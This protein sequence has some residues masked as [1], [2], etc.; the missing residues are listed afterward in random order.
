[1]RFI[2]SSKTPR[3][4]DASIRCHARPGTDQLLSEHVCVLRPGRLIVIVRKISKGGGISGF[5][6]D[7]GPSITERVGLSTTYRLDK[8]K[9]WIGKHGNGLKPVENETIPPF[10]L[11]KL[12]RLKRSL[13]EK[14][15]LALIYRVRGRLSGPC[16]LSRREDRHGQCNQH[17]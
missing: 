8:I 3:C 16:V 13:D 11:F 2:F 15:L 9:A 12:L 7:V 1:M 6:E 10:R 14:G 4:D 5:V 17:D